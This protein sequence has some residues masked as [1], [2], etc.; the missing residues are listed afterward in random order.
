MALPRS[1][2]GVA[3]RRAAWLKGLHGPKSTVGPR[4]SEPHTRISGLPFHGSRNALLHARTF[5][6]PS[7]KDGSTSVSYWPRFTVGARFSE[8]HTQTPGVPFHCSGNSLF[9]ARTF[10]P[11]FLKAG[12]TS[13]SGGTGGARLGRARPYNLWGPFDGSLVDNSA[14]EPTT[15][16]FPSS[17][18]SGARKIRKLRAQLAEEDV[19]RSKGSLRLTSAFGISVGL[20]VVAISIVSARKQ[21]LKRNHSS[22]RLKKPKEHR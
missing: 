5:P 18:S 2:V 17:Q 3:P 20:A 6:P 15:Y 4:F 19:N 1:I 11:P 8:L 10:P 9:Q 21:G 13:V 7:L 16:S 14:V 22:A 12:N